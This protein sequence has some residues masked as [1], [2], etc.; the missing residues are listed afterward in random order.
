MTAS[1]TPTNY[2]PAQIALHWVVVLGVVIQIAMHDPMVAVNEAQW[3]GLAPLAADV[4]FA[5]MHV[6]VGSIILLAVIGRLYMRFRYGAPGHAPG[7]PPMQAK[8]ATL[9][10]WGLYA[11]LLGM[12][13]TGMLTWNGIAALGDVHF[14]IN[15]AL[16]VMVLAHAGAALFNQ[17]V[18]KDGTMRRMLRSTGN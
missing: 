13:I 6:G 10:H 9:M 2:R 3:E 17:F 8:I 4:P 5:W 7:T 11:A 15:V 12:V 18:R 16:F 14:A 1:T